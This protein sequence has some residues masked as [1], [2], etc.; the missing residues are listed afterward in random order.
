LNPLYEPSSD[1]VDILLDF[2]WRVRMDGSDP[3]RFGRTAKVWQMALK[4]ETGVREIG[5]PTHVILDPNNPWRPFL[6]IQPSMRGLFVMQLDNHL[7]SIG[8]LPS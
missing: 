5:L 7:R 6:D 2:Y 3:T 1:D 4:G 8:A